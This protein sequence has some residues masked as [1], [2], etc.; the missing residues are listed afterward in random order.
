VAV[1]TIGAVT[2][3][4]VADKN[5]HR[6][7]KI[8]TDGS[9]TTLAGSDAGVSGNTDD[10]GTDARFNAP[11]ALAVDATGNVYV[12]D[13]NNQRIR[14]V[15]PAGVVTTVAIDA[16]TFGSVKGIA[17]DTAGNIYVC[18]SQRI[19]KVTEA[20]V[21]TLVAGQAASGSANGTG[22]AATFNGPRGLAVDAGGRIYVADE[23]NNMIRKIE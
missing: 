21:V 7:R 6:I 18:G 8:A 5:S 2:T 23:V 1:G 3:I 9:I 14:K 17:V 10:T 15:T 22:A 20:G 12:A 4:Y 19:W 16:G 13:T 11:Q